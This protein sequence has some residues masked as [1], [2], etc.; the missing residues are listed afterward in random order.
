M[1]DIQPEQVTCCATIK[2]VKGPATGRVIRLN[3]GE[4]LSF[5]RANEN[6]V[7]IDDLDVSRHHCTLASVHG[8]VV[9]TDLKSSNGTFVAGKRITKVILDG[10]T[11]IAL[12]SFGTKLEF[13][14]RDSHEVEPDISVQTEAQIPQERPRLAQRRS[15]SRTPCRIAVWCNTEDQAFPGIVTDIGTGGLALQSDVDLPEGTLVEV[16]PRENRYTSIRLAIRWRHAGAT[17]QRYGTC[18]AE[19]LDSLRSSWVSDALRALGRDARTAQDRRADIR[20]KAVFNCQLESENESYSLQSVNLGSSGLCLQGA[21]VPEVQQKLEVKIA[22]TTVAVQVKWV[23]SH[24][25]GLGFVDLNESQKGAID[26]LVH[27]YLAPETPF[28]LATPPN[29]GENLGHYQLGPLIGEGGFGR[30]YRAYDSRLLRDVAIKILVGNDITPQSLARFLIE[31]RAVARVSHPGVITI[32]EIATGPHHYIVME[33]LHGEPLSQLLSRGALSSVR[34]IKLIRQVVDALQV[35]HQA[36]VIHRDLNTANIMVCA[37]DKI[38]VLDFGLAK[39]SDQ[40]SAVSQA[41]Q[42]WGTPQYMAP[43][44]IDSCYGPVDHQT[45]IFAASSV[46][47]EM[48]TG[49]PAFQAPSIPKLIYEILYNDPPDPRSLNPELAENLCLTLMKGLSKSK[50]ERY[51]NCAD[52]LRALDLLINPAGL[53]GA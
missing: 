28:P 16:R 10:P 19:N 37:N 17:P 35:V 11:Q 24:R 50:E 52:Y 46:L 20:V 9:L 2:I 26:G 14:Y 27:N 40:V 51:E 12:G 48:L 34:A 6:D 29:S 36:G 41:G 47:Y 30:V 31:A 13:C 33:L 18:Y 1:S 21:R 4:T 15:K 7:V 45:D 23:Q 38:K 39:F 3:T 53:S 25:C 8:R 5:G 42:V 22:E 43:E 49:R 44:Q 32:Y